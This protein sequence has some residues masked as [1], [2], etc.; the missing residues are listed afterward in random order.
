MGTNDSKEN[1]YYVY[2]NTE[3]KYIRKEPKEVKEYIDSFD[4][5]SLKIIGTFDKYSPRD[6]KELELGD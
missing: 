2:S 6:I 5:D 4:K 3:Q 1:F